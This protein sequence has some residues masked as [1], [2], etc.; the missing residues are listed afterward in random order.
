MQTLQEL[1][2]LTRRLSGAEPVA[3]HSGN[4]T[5][6]QVCEHLAKTIE[7]SCPGGD[8]GPA[9]I[10]RWIQPIAR[11]VFF[12]IPYVPAGRPAPP[13]ILPGETSATDKAIE[14]LA[15]AVQDFEKVSLPLRGR[16]VSHP[17]FGVLS[18]EQWRKVHLVHGKHHLKIFTG[19]RC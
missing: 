11:R 14:R 13:S 10:P 6:A 9:A 4:W 5:L 16:M 19:K 8:M 15:G 7:Q 18:H 12:L 17:A 1:V 3:S 2:G